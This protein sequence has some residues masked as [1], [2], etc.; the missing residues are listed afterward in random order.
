MVSKLHAKLS[1]AL[2]LKLCTC[3]Y[4]P[5]PSLGLI[6]AMHPSYLQFRI[7]GKSNRIWSKLSIHAGT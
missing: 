2:S 7:G 5:Q 4:V 1:L 3:V 6:D